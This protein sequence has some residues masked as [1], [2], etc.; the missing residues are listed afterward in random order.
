MVG[1]MLKSGI[2]SLKRY[3]IER[4]MVTQ[5]TIGVGSLSIVSVNQ[6]HCR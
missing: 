5:T 4:E 3:K 1:R 2:V 6:C